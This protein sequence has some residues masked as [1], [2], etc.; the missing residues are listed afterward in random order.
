MHSLRHLSNTS[1]IHLDCFVFTLQKH[2]ERAQ[3][4]P[5]GYLFY[6]FRVNKAGDQARHTPFPHI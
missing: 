5:G 2:K 1:V 4:A 3:N 6:P